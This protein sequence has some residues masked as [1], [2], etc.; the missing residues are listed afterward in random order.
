MHPLSFGS[1]ET[2]QIRS[3]AGMF[4]YHISSRYSRYMGPSNIT[5]RIG[6]FKVNGGS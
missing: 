6:N 3:W 1:N 2:K 4:L 5:V